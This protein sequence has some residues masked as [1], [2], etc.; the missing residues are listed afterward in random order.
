L[1]PIVDPDFGYASFSEIFWE[2]RHGHPQLDEDLMYTRAIVGDM[3]EQY[4]IGNVYFIGHSNGGVFGL[5]LALYFPNLFTGI[6]SHCGGLGFDPGLYLNFKLL[7]EDDKKTPLLFYT[8]DNDLHKDACI[9]AKIVFESEGFPIVD[10]FIEKELEHKYLPTCE[11][12]ILNW[13][14]SLEK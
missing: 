13:F 11:P 12:Y 5:L 1:P 10:I 14:E 3:K 7:K 6:T 8:G 9:A 4:N 2:I